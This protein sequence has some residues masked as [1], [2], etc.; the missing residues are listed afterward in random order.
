MKYRTKMIRI[1]AKKKKKKKSGII[2]L[3]RTR[4]RHQRRTVVIMYSTFMPDFVH[5]TDAGTQWLQVHVVL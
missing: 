1:R 4:R 2:T 3:Y 5:S